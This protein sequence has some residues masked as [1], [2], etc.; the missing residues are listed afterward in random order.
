MM[1][2]LFF[3]ISTI[4]F[5][6]SA[7]TDNDSFSTDRSHRL[8]FSVDTIRLDTLFSTVPSSTYTFWVYNK[9]NDGI[10]IRT[11]RLERGNQSGF[12]VNV[13]GVFLNPSASGFELREGDSLRVFVEVTTHENLTAD[14]QLVEDHLLF[15]LESGVEQRMN[16]RTYSWD[17]EK[18]ENL[19]VTEDMTI[20]SDKP[21]VLYGTGIEI[22]KSAT[23]TIRNT[24][25]Y[26]HDNAGISVKGQLVAENCLFRGDRLDHMFNYLPYDRISGQWKG[27]AVSAK[28]AGCTMTDCEI[29]SAYTGLSCDSTIVALD[30]TVIHNCRGFG[31]YAHDS[32]VSVTNCQMSNTLNDCLAL[33][34]CQATVD[35]TTLAQFY[36]F[37]A[38]RGAAIR[39]GYTEQ[40]YELTCTNTLVTGYANDVLVG[41]KT[42]EDKGYYFQNCILRTPEINDPES[43]KDV[44]WEK[45]DDPI[46]GLKHFV[47]ADEDKFIYDFTIKEESPAYERSIGRKNNS[48]K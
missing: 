37:S 11:A 19:Q 42:D 2:R 32:E 25:L 14:P 30:N 1:K 34:G 35:Q 6:L 16:L 33:L 47:L 15:T 43:F 39:F 41:E 27:I 31:L 28:A 38:V 20:E 23:L 7:C 21:I 29:H 45:N 8:T 18:I 36:P 24:E 12:R 4:V 40:P 9:N 46:Q 3:F 44:I 22:A 17:A 26:F 10:R 48:E 5:L 13:D